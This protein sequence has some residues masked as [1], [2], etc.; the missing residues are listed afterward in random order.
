MGG[1]PRE[2]FSGLVPR[3]EAKNIKQPVVNNAANNGTGTIPAS[4]AV[5]PAATTGT[6]H[7]IKKGDTLYAIAKANNTTVSNLVK[8]NGFKNDK[9]LILPGKT[10]KIK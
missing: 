8:L 3:F 6:T 7:T 4:N 10:I 5:V 9:A 2:L 1:G